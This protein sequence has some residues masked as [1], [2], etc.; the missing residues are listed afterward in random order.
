MKMNTYLEMDKNLDSR[1]EFLS[2]HPRIDIQDSSILGILE[3]DNDIARSVSLDI[4]T[5]LYQDEEAEALKSRK[6]KRIK[7][8]VKHSSSSSKKQWFGR[9]RK[10]LRSENPKVRVRKRRLSVNGV[11][12]P[13]NQT[14]GRL[15]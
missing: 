15:L 3:L 5:I 1:G 4:H 10:L 6:K 14:G 7:V 8:N 9:I 12:Q 11:V 13:S 2:V